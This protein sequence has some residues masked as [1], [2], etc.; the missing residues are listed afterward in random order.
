MGSDE[1]GRA[2]QAAVEA[3][4]IPRDRPLTND[5]IERVSQ[6]MLGGGTEGPAVPPQAATNNPAG[7][8][9]ANIVGPGARSGRYQRTASASPITPPGNEGETTPGPTSQVER[10]F[11]PVTAQG[12][13]GTPG[14][15]GGGQP[16]ETQTP[17]L[18]SAGIQ[19]QAA[20]TQL[21]PGVA[22]A[23]AQ[24]GP[25]PGR[26]LPQPP[27]MPRPEDL[28]PQ[29]AMKKAQEFQDYAKRILAA[30]PLF[31]MLGPAGQAQAAEAYKNAVATAQQYRE[32]GLGQQKLSEPEQQAQRLGMTLPQF[33]AHETAITNDEKDFA[34]ESK[35]IYATGNQAA[36]SQHMIR[37]GEAFVNSPGFHSGVMEPTTRLFKQWAVAFGAK[38]DTAMSQEGF[39]KVV[40]NILN[41]Q[42]RAMG[43]SGVGRV[44]LAEVNNMKDGIASLKITPQTNLMLL[45]ILKRVYQRQ[46]DVA[47]LV[48]GVRAL[49]GQRYGALNDAIRNYQNAK[50]MFSDAELADTRLIA[51]PMV[52]DRAD[53]ARWGLGS[54]DP[55]RWNGQIKYVP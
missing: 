37:A 49:P 41:E 17:A 47:G 14:V 15:T 52:K 42:I 43:Q 27:S 3:T 38:P 20:P 26:G 19:P 36:E 4:G 8:G 11:A 32:F 5:Q 48:G 51:P 23:Y 29:Q 25:A 30:S 6:H 1:A 40:M 50:P 18:A 22:N 53:I 21:P 2:I 55:V 13:S 7:A 28:S 39:N 31:S 35:K 54:G 33:K 45:E 10:N 34:D 24:A 16:A 46:M 12:A 9:V 44:L